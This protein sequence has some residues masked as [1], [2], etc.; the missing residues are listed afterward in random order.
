MTTAAATTDKK[1]R[2]HKLPKV[3]SKE[4]IDELLLTIN[5]KCPTGCRNYAIM[6]TMYRAGL[7]VAEVCNL[8]PADVKLSER[9][10]QVQLGKGL[11]DRNVYIDN[12][13][14]KALEAWGKIRPESEYFFSTLEGSKVSDRYIREV[15]RRMSEKSG[16][17]LQDGREQKAIFPHA[18]RHTFATEAIEDGLGIHEVQ[19]LMGHSNIQTTS[20]YL[21]V[22]D[23]ELKEKILNRD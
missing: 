11:K 6:M 13:L 8:S 2:V 4:E 16:V 14:L 1:K 5:R 21:S 20:I 9:I 23:A 19:K 7:R 15:C 12:K 10:I 18:F 22:R 17:Y 3:L